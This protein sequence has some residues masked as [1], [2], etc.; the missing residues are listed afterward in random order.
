MNKHNQITEI[1][2]FSSLNLLVNKSDQFLMIY[3]YK[4]NN[5]N[6]TYIDQ[7]NR[8]IRNYGKRQL[9]LYIC[10]VGK[11]PGMNQ[12]EPNTCIYKNGFKLVHFYGHVS[13]KI[14]DTSIQRFVS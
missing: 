1:K 3:F 13:Q 6:Q 10:D 4:T 5:C 9:K 7:L 14:I 2:D 11:F 8:S 12:D